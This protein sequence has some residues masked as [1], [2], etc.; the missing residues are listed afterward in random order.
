MYLRCFTSDQ[1]KEWGKWLAWVEYNYN[2]SWHSTIKTT[3]FVAVYGRDP[4]SMLTYIS[5]T[6]KAEAV[7]RAFVARDQVLR[8]LKDN[9]KLAQGRMKK[10]YDNKHIED[11]FQK[12]D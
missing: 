1:P 12:G 9:I 4:P 3:L 10:L 6:A 8:E 2:T 11:G 7:E 5:G